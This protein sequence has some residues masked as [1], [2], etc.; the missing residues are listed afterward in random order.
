M[1]PEN[2]KKYLWNLWG[3]ASE[4][5]EILDAWEIILWYGLKIK[6]SKV[7]KK[8]ILLTKTENDRMIIFD[9]FESIKRNIIPLLRK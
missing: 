2:I 7:F 8:A 5:N 3:L 1:K 4:A 6:P 9:R